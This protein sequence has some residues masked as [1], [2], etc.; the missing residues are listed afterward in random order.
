MFLFVFFFFS[1]QNAYF[2]FYLECV[3]KTVSKNTPRTCS[4]GLDFSFVV[5]IWTRSWSSFLIFMQFLVKNGQIIG[6]CPLFEVGASLWEILDQPLVCVAKFLHV[7]MK[8]LS[9][10]HVSK[11]FLF[12]GVFLFVTVTVAVSELLLVRYSTKFQI[13]TNISYLITIFRLITH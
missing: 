11:I 10:N 6:W 3:L 8:F 9:L 2:Y 5:K 13:S 1:S 7:P 4:E 12:C